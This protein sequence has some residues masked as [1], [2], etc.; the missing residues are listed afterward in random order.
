MPNWLNGMVT[1]AKDNRAYAAGIVI[2]LLVMAWFL[3]IP[4]DDPEVVE[5]QQEEDLFGLG[6]CPATR[7][8]RR[9]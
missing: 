3:F 9:R 7:R 1:W 8:R 2:G 4:A 5:Q 6:R